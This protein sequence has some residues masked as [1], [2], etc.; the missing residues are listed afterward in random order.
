V[1]AEIRR[2]TAL[3][4]SQNFQ[5]L[6]CDPVPTIFDEAF[7]NGADNIGHFERRP[8]HLFVRIVC[9][10]WKQSIERTDGC[11]QMAFR[12]VKIPRR[13]FKAA[14]PQQELN[15]TQIR[16]VIEQVGCEA[17]SKHMRM[18]LLFQAASFGC[19]L[20]GLPG[21]FSCDRG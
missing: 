13:L 7:S 6:S 5:V 14:V 12:Y 15:G 8:L 20:T 4:C 16:T 18:N 9:F 11:A 10:I 2:A 3:D 19:S 1:I 21:D 17:M